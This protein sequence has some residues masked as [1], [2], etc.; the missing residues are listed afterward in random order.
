[1]D[2]PAVAQGIEALDVVHKLA[3]LLDTGLKREEVAILI[4]LIENGV[5]PEVR[6]DV[7]RLCLPFP[8]WLLFGQC[9]TA[10]HT[11]P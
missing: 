4:A 2:R 7:C 10:S 3:T 5:N 1:M 9:A 8:L 6:A 11:V